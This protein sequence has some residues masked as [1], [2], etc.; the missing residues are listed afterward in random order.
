[1]IFI[2]CY[3]LVSDLSLTLKFKQ[4]LNNSSKFVLLFLTILYSYITCKFLIAQ[5][6]PSAS[7]RNLFRARL[8][9]TLVPSAE[10][11]APN[12]NLPYHQIYQLIIVLVPMRIGRWVIKNVIS[13]FGTLIFYNLVLLIH[14]SDLNPMGNQA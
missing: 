5:K 12:Y 11:R 14:R 7:H 4:N 1:M 10:S 13:S 3:Y 6:N 8:G 9:S 2:R